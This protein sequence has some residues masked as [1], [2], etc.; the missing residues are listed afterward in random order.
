MDGE[1]RPYSVSSSSGQN[2][3]S[4]TSYNTAS[5]TT[6]VNLGSS[7]S[8]QFGYDPNT[9]WMTQYEFNVGSQSITGALTW[10]AVGTLASLGITDPFDTSNAQSCSYSHDDLT[11]ILSAILYLPF[12]VPHLARFLRQVGLRPSP[13]RLQRYP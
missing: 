10:N 6:Q 13:H 5:A 2:P 7:D 9:G 11:R 1:G 12:R 3:V 4:S 8:D